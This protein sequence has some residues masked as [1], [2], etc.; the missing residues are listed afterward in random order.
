MV[1]IKMFCYEIQVGVQ[2]IDFIDDNLGLFLPF[3]KFYASK[4]NCKE[5]VKS[6]IADKWFYNP[7]SN[8]YRGTKEMLGIHWLGTERR[9]CIQQMNKDDLI[10]VFGRPSREDKDSNRM[11]YLYIQ[12]DFARFDSTKDC[13]YCMFIQLTDSGKVKHF[14][15]PVMG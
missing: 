1:I 10:E 11:F 3:I 4:K 7:E 2:V 12:E 13:S 6:F 9:E 8:I 14:S 15:F 5:V